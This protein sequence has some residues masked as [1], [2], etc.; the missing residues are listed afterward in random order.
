MKNNKLMFDTKIKLNR[1][2]ITPVIFVSLILFFILWFLFGFNTRT[3]DLENYKMFYLHAK[4]GVR[5]PGI[6]SGYYFFLRFCNIVGLSFQQYMI[7]YSFIG[8]VLIL[9]SV[10]KYTDNKAIISTILFIIFPY[11]Y[12]IV[13]QRYFMA[14]AI[15][16][17]SIRYLLYDYQYGKIKFIFCILLAAT[18]HTYSLMALIYLVSTFKNKT[19][20]LSLIFILVLSILIIF[21]KGPIFI[22]FTHFF[23]KLSIYLLDNTRISTKFFLG[24]YFLLKLLFCELVNKFSYE[25]NNKLIKINKLSIF[26][27]P[28]SIISMNFMRI[29]YSMLVFLS[30][31]IFR[32]NADKLDQK[33]N[34]ELFVIKLLY[35][36]FYLFFAYFLLYLYSFETVVKMII[37][38]NLLLR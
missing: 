14:T 31:L 10:N 28:L 7:F 20:N 2:N 34:T 35:I 32:T 8:S 30:I 13:A 6:E 25:G 23:P 26:T 27:F 18:F 19:I 24:V 1:P 33:K 22:P 36:I 15:I 16:I 9:K 38:N 4:N 12:F 17:W 11:F 21:F 37:E 5:F 29:E 3:V